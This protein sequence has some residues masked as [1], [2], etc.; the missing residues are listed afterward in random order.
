MRATAAGARRCGRRGRGCTPSTWPS[1]T[2]SRGSRWRSIRPCRPTW[3]RCWGGCADP[4]SRS[5]DRNG[6]HGDHSRSEDAGVG[7][8]D[9]FDDRP[10]AL[11]AGHPGDVGQRHLVEVAAHVLAQHPPDGQQHALALVV[12]GT[13]LVRLAE[14]AHGDRPV[15]GADDVAQRDGGRFPGEDVAAAHSPLRA[16]Q[17]R[18]LERQQDL[19]QVGLGEPGAL[20]DVPDRGRPGLG[21]VQRQRQQRPAGVVTACRDLH[22]GQLYGPQPRSA[23]LPLMRVA[24]HPDAAGRSASGA[25]FP[26]PGAS[27]RAARAPAS[28]PLGLRRRVSRSRRFAPGRSGPGLASARPLGSSSGAIM[29]SSER[30]RYGGPRK[31]TGVVDEPLLPDYGGACVTNVVPALLGPPDGAPAWLPAIAADARQVVLFVLD[32]MG[33]DQLAARGQLAPT[34]SAMEGGPI[35]TVAPSTTSTALTSIT[36]GLPPGEHGIVGYRMAVHGEVLN[37]LRWTTAAGDA[38]QSLPPAK[39][40][41]IAPFLGERPPVVTR[42]EYRRSGFTGAHLDPARFWGYRTMATM[43]TEVERLLRSSEPFVYAYYDGLDKVAH[44]YGLGEHYDAELAWIDHT[45]ERILTELRP[46][47]ALVVTADHGQVEV[48]GNVLPLAPEVL[49]HCQM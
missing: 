48:G 18:T 6:R 13:V 3:P 5:G 27:G 41:T 39:I 17:P 42:A 1:T 49:A 43:V 35:T 38:H 2:R 29:M 11:A 30:G 40:Q 7:S 10:L 31:G 15:D 21:R 45:V 34:L 14:V 26:A 36:T 19:L 12:A 24:R 47:C 22:A 28:R 44:E 32:G 4:L 8:V 9:R 33:W 23:E 16:D 25:V 20:G 46:G 37:V